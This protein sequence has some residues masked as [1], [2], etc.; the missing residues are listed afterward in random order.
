MKMNRKVV[1]AV[2]ALGLTV[3]A[4]GGDDSSDADEPTAD[5]T[6]AEDTA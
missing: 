5:A 3:A 2:M 1:G 6:E 4:C